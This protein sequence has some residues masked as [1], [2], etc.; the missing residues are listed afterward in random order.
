M[1]RKPDPYMLLNIAHVKRYIPEAAQIVR[2]GW[3]PTQVSKGAILM[4]NE[5]LRYLVRESLKK[6]PA[7][8][9]TFTEVC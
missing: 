3:I 4:L 7:R 8:G 9:K 2:P 1:K 6:H 5:K